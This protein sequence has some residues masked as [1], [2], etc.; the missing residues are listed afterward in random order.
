M[1]QLATADDDEDD[2]GDDDDVMTFKQFMSTLLAAAAAAATATAVLIFRSTISVDDNIAA[3]PEVL[4]DIGECS[5]IF[6]EACSPVNKFEIA[7]F[8][9][10][11]LFTF[12]LLLFVLPLIVALIMSLLLSSS[13]LPFDVTIEVVTGDDN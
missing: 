8:F 1:P 3:P 7:P 6:G 9:T 12:L 10:I 2:V 4:I 5:A 13:S 11:L